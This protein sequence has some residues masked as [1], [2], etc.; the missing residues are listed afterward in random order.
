MVLM[1]LH[2][3]VCLEAAQSGIQFWQTQ[4]YLQLNCVETAMQATR[5][6]V[7]EMQSHYEDK[8]AEMNLEIATLRDECHRELPRLNIFTY[9]AHIR[10]MSGH[11]LFF[12]RSHFFFGWKY[13]NNSAV[14]FPLGSIFLFILA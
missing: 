6:Q 13:P 9:H 14:N 7:A 12:Q 3:D 5:L 11:L 2:P 4:S 8:I 10:R 1:G